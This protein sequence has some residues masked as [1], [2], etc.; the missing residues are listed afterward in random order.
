M[1]LVGS[2]VEL[3]ADEVR[4]QAERAGAGARGSGGVGRTR[5]PAGSRLAGRVGRAVLHAEERPAGPGSAARSGAAQP[6]AGP[7]LP[8]ASGFLRS[9]SGPDCGLPYKFRGVSSGRAGQGCLVTP[10]ARAGTS[11]RRPGNVPSGP[12]PLAASPAWAT[13]VTRRV[14]ARRRGLNAPGRGRPTC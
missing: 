1:A 6:G 8:G 9:G 11:A 7:S 10:G 13:E 14:L 12:E 3:D 4:R 2:R 5:R